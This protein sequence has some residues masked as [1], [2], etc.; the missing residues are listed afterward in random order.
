[1][2]VNSTVNTSWSIYSGMGETW[3][4]AFLVQFILFHIFS[5]NMNYIS[6]KREDCSTMSD[7]LYTALFLSFIQKDNETIATARR[8][9]HCAI[10]PTERRTEIEMSSLI[11][12]SPSYY[13][14]SL[15]LK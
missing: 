14:H 13:I 6:T 3:S 2:K 8:S 10:K 7:I 1:M 15:L 5:C 9:L 11:F 4:S 12:S